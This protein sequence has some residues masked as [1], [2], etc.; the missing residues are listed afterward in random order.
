MTRAHNPQ[1]ERALEL[2][3]TFVVLAVNGS[4]CDAFGHLGVLRAIL[5]ELYGPT[6]VETGVGE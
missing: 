6:W 2:G 4:R 1:R 3:L 5:P